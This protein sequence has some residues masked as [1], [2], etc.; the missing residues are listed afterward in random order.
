MIPLETNFLNVLDLSLPTFRIVRHMGRDDQ[1]DICFII[2]KC[3]YN[4]FG[5]IDE[6]LHRLHLILCCHST[7]G[8]R[9]AILMG[10][11]SAA[12]TPLNRIEICE[13]WSSKPEFTRP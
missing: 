13:R 10:T 5:K 11:L 3:M 8:W 2:A 1:C 7:T 4:Q 9:I 6:N 12:V